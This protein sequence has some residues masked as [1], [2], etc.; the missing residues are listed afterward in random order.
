MRTLDSVNLKILETLQRDCTLSLEA[1]SAQVGISKSPCWT[2]LRW[3]K[4]QGYLRKSVALLDAERLGLGCT[5]F[6]AVKTS[7]HE[8]SWLESFAT[9]VAAMPEV[10]EFHRLSGQID[11]LLKVVVRDSA[12]YDRF[13]KDLIGRVQLSDVSASFS[14]EQIKCTTELPLEACLP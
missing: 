10:L 9:T 6:V 5:V 7:R 11:Y 13:Y 14:M 8:A 4:E 12:D 2:R 3:L 1:V